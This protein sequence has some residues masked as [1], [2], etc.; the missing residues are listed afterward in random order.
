MVMDV[1]FATQTLLQQ[2]HFS[3]GDV[4]QVLNLERFLHPDYLLACVWMYTH[5]QIF[6]SLTVAAVHYVRER[7]SSRLKGK[8]EKCGPSGN[9]TIGLL[10]SGGVLAKFSLQTPCPILVKDGRYSH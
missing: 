4:R 3:H 5:Q 6:F 10:E 1:C 2:Y 7:D 8:A 9:A